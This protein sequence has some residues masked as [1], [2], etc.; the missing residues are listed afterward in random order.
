MTSMKIV[1]L[2]GPP[3]PLSIYVQNSSTPLTL[4]VQFQMNSVP[5]FQMINQSIKKKA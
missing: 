5:P 2:S 1:Q 4:D 3:T